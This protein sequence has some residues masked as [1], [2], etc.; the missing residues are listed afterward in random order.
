M[1]CNSGVGVR[2]RNTGIISVVGK[3][4]EEHTV[5]VDVL[6][7]I[8]E[9]LQKLVLIAAAANEGVGFQRRFKPSNSLK[10]QHNLRCAVPTAGSYAIAIVEVDERSQEDLPQLDNGYSAL[11]TVY[12]FTDAVL[13]N[14]L[15][16]VQQLVPES[17]L[18]NLMLRTLHDIAPKEGAKWAID[19][20]VN[21]KQ[22]KRIGFKVRRDVTNILKENAP[23]E[24]EG[25]VIGELQRI[26][27]DE[28][29]IEIRHP[30]TEQLIGCTY[31]ND[32][33]ADIW[34]SRRDNVQVIGKIIRS[35]NEHVVSVSDVVSIEQ[36]DLSAYE[37][38]EVS[39]R[40]IS[41]SVSPPLLVEPR[42]DEDTKQFFVYDNQSLQIYVVANTRA[43]LYEQ[44]V[45]DLLFSY[46][47]YALVS[48]DELTSDAIDFK[49]IL[50]TRLTEVQDG[51]A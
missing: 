39:D 27:L 40:T 42:L 6:V 49:G 22:S 44:I 1:I 38:S 17:G 16:D 35:E 34:E 3:E 28:N 30:V 2:E 4:T 14:K 18:R 13:D 45:D 26:L 9:R 36:V 25:S 11:D 7:Q 21:T 33:E 46:K 20:G 43:E 47:E 23:A 10:L 29:K 24:E 8:L 31:D 19:F 5:P 15:A 37:I 51:P 32:V 50:A 48:D 41:L 12:K